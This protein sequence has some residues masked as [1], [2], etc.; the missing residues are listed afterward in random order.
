MYNVEGI[1]VDDFMYIE[2]MYYK[3][4][5]KKNFT[6]KNLAAH[7]YVNSCHA[8]FLSCEKVIKDKNGTAKDTIKLYNENTK[9]RSSVESSGEG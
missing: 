6:R 8:K 7:R 1:F 9:S 4:D 3:L 2:R 5:R